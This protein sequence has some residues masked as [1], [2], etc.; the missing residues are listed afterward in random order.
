MTPMNLQAQINRPTRFATLTDV[1][2]ILLLSGVFSLAQFSVRQGRAV[3]CADSLQYLDNAELILSPDGEPSF[4]YRKPG[5]SYML[6]GLIAWLGPHVWGFVAANYLL[7]SIFPLLAYAL[8]RCLRSRGVGW[9]A[10]ILTI[11]RLRESIWA[12]RVMSE[13]AYTFV[14]SIGIVM[15]SYALSRLGYAKRSSSH[16]STLHDSTNACLNNPLTD[17]KI[18]FL[19]ALAGVFVAVAWFIRP[20]ALVILAASVL[21]LIWLRRN[22]FAHSMVLLGLLAAPTAGAVLVECALNNKGG[23]EFRP[24]TGTIGAMTLMRARHVQGIPMSESAVATKCAAFLPE[25]T[26]EDAYRVNHVDVWVARDHLIREMKMNDWEVDRQLGDA[27]W[28]LIRRHPGEYLVIGLQVF[29]RTLLRQTSGPAISRVPVQDLQPIMR[30]PSAADD[31]QFQEHWYAYWALPNR[32]LESSLSLF[33]RWDESARTKAAIEGEPFKSLRYL[34]MAAPTSD[35]FGM[36]GKVGSLWP[37]FA[38]LLC[39][40]LGLDRRV[41]AFLAVCYVLDA[42][43]VGTFGACE[44]AIARYEWVWFV[45]DTTLAAALFA[46]LVSRP[47]R[48][49]QPS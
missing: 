47:A 10:A 40:V 2:V 28:D 26:V 3:L 13:V 29:G 11:V 21:L 32:P 23:G 18:E 42:A 15:V 36:M 46:P 6:A 35:V 38:I 48:E 22:R 4:G 24:C 27:G 49:L 7:Q 19:F 39:G 17:R 41:C 31:L 45:C 9:L 33:N 1:V 37:G 20:V 34:F 8:G 30:H 43:L 16:E 25:R 14:A 12:E 44:Q 5:Y